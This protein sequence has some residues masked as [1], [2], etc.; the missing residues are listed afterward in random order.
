MNANRALSYL[1][2]TLVAVF[3]AMWLWA[4]SLPGDSGAGMVLTGVV[5][6]FSFLAVPLCC[7]GMLVGLVS[8]QGIK[9][10]LVYGLSSALGLTGFIIAR[11]LFFH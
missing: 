5:Y 1:V 6:I 2:I 7:L 8:K 9:V 3:G 4:E 11:L 10:G